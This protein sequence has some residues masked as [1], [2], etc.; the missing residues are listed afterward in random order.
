[1]IEFLV[2]YWGTIVV[3][4]FVIVLMAVPAVGVDAAIAPQGAA[5]IRSNLNK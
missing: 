5:S 3:S 2:Q 1:M 4:V